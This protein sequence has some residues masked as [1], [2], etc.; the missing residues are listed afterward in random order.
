[1]SSSSRFFFLIV[2]PLVQSFYSIE[3]MGDIG[4]NVLIIHLM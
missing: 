4:T 2:A 3:G 1:M